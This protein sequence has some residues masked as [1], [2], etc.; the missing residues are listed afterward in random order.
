[1]DHKNCARYGEMM[2]PLV[3]DANE[4]L[5]KFNSSTQQ[6]IKDLTNINEAITDTT[7]KFSAS[8]IMERQD[9]LQ[10]SLIDIPTEF[11]NKMSSAK[12]N[13]QEIQKIFSEIQRDLQ[14][15]AKQ[16]NSAQALTKQ[17]EDET[18]FFNFGDQVFEGDDFDLG[19]EQWFSSI[20]GAI[21]MSKLA[22]KDGKKTADE[23]IKA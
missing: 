2:L 17:F 4:K 18:G 22:G 14:N 15:Q 5:T 23:L 6:Y 16:A 7:G 13:V 8:D 12:G 1:M 9:A 11:L 3:K 21:D 20:K 19:Q 10:A